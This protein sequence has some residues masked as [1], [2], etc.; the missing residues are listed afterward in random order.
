MNIP[1]NLKYY[2]H[3]RHPHEMAMTYVFIHKI[4]KMNC[5]YTYSVYYPEILF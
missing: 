5:N 3:F 4:V 1:T 2:E